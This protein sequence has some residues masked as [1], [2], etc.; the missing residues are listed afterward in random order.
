MRRRQFGLGLLAMPALARRAAAAEQS[1][2]RIAR[3]AELSDLPLMV[4]Q[5]K[6]LVESHA[7]KQGL[8]SLRAAWPDSRERGETI[9]MLLSGRA[10][11]GILGAPELTD[12]WDRTVG[13][14]GEVRALS[15]VAWQP[16]MLVTRDPAVKT[17]ADFSPLDVIA[18]PRVKLSPQAVC[19]EMA[20]AK[21]WG[22]EAY[23][24][25]DPL[26]MSL[27]NPRAEE[28]VIT[29]RPPVNSHYAVSPYYY[30]ELA[31]RGVHLVLKSNDTLGGRHVNGLLVAAPFFH[32]RNPTITQ[33]VLAAQ[34]EANAFIK[35]HP[36]MAAEIYL[37][38]SG[39]HRDKD[40]VAGMIADPDIVWTTVPRRL[41]AFA[42]FLHG[43]GRLN[44]MP[45]SWK[46]LMLPEG[47]SGAGS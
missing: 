45:A 10:D 33:A 46:D 35:A 41:M 40:D 47:Q 42:R 24:R 13:T 34:E 11:F 16:F 14:P 9:S 15:A 19:L 44:R 31:T 28:S 4:M 25:L 27:A 38:L 5:H 43:I 2:V 23:A 26:T 18:V 20:A 17:L 7:R 30:D 3:G 29:G 21:L 12:L 32:A 39:D 37:T 8:A 22:I 1:L 36:K 6:E